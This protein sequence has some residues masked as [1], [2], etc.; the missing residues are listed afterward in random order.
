MSLFSEECLT[1][2]PHIRRHGTILYQNDGDKVL[3][4]YIVNDRYCIR[5]LVLYSNIQFHW[6]IW[7]Q[8]S[9]PVQSAAVILSACA[10]IN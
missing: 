2:R 6:I 8:Q 10:I 1:K 7:L 5:I 4:F 9:G 3:F